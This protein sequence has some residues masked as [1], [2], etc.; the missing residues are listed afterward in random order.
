[1]QT[2][3]V[4]CVAL[5]AVLL[6]PATGRAEILYT[7]VNLSGAEFGEGNLPG[8]HEFDSTGQ[9]SHYTHPRNNEVDYFMGKGMNVFRLPFRW[10]RLQRTLNGGFDATE[11]SRMNSFVDYATGRGAYVILDPHNYGRYWVGGRPGGFEGVVGTGSVT[12]A[13]FA[14]FWSRLA[15]EYKD[16]DRVIFNLINEPHDMPSTESWADSANAAIAAIRDAGA[17]NLILVP[18]NGWTGAHSWTQNWYGTPNATAMLDIVDPGNNFAFDVHQYL[19]SDSSGTSAFIV[20]QTIGAERLGAM[21]QW[22]EDNN[23]RAFLGEFAVANSTVGGGIG[24]EAID[25][26]LDYME[27]HSDVWLGWAWWGGGPWWGNYMF[28]LDPTNIGQPNETDRAAMAVLVP[29][30]V[31]NIIVVPDIPGDADGDGDVDADDVNVVAQNFGFPVTGGAAFGDFNDDGDV[32]M[33]DLDIVLANFGATPADAPASLPEPA[34]VALLAVCAAA[35]S[36][37]RHAA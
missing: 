22:L 36:A 16:N 34:A 27:A 13:A 12:D 4:S 3:L 9:P 14:D 2:F 29:H 10:E 26:M 23:Q 21:T 37:R 35:L 8:L 30:L 5:G 25:N 15:D 17:E 18:G 33:D 24:D 1:L 28:A 32:N 6:H 31:G 7:G 19:D 20:S 11:L